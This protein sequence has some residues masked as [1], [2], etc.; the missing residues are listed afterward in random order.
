LLNFTEIRIKLVPNQ[1]DKLRAFASITL[2]DALVIRDIK[3]IDGGKRL[4]VA[5]PSR[6]LCDRC[7]RCGGKNT[8][9][10]RFCNDCGTRLKS[11]RA[12]LDERGR[13]R[14]YADITHP[15]HKE[16]RAQ[17]Q[18]A[19]L[20][21][22]QAEVTRSKEAGYVAQRFDDMDYEAWEEGSEGGESNEA[23]GAGGAA[24]E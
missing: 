17:I 22:Y 24:T 21:A 8:I 10:S 20:D 18:T 15:I 11:E 12:E 6:K 19:I 1:R 5:M 7:K 16:A 14:L 3:I 13:P 23:G 4:F 9:R 2:D